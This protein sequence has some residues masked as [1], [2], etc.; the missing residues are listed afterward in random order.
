M[1]LHVRH[2]AD[3]HV[4]YR[5]VYRPLRSEITD[6]LMLRLRSRFGSL[7]FP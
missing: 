6:R 7:S 5:Q 3:S 2:D 1:T 4:E